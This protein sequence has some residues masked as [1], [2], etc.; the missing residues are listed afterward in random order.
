MEQR[1]LGRSGL[2]VSRLALGTMTWGRDT[3]Q[4]EAR[5]QLLAFV[6]MGGTL[7]DTADVY[8]DGMSEEIVGMLVPEIGR[9]SLVIATKAVS[10]PGSARRFDAS[11]G[12]L[13]RALDA[14]LTR[15]GVDYIDLWQLHA[16]D[17]ATPY[18][19]TLSAVDVAVAS[20]KVRYA[21][22]SN[23]NGWQTAKAA[24]MQTSRPGAAQFVSTQ[25]EYS[26]LERGV[27]RE[28]VGAAADAGLGLLP[29]SPLGR[30]VLTGKYRNGTPADS[31]AASS[32]F[33]SFISPYLGDDSRRVVDALCTAA[34]GLGVSPL[35]V[36]LAW[37]RDRPGVVAPIIGSRTAAQLRGALTVEELT[38]PDEI[39]NALD[40]V[41][42][43]ALGYPDHGWNQI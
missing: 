30:G 31:R 22:I 28:V 35:E 34:E 39:V 41:S 1:P 38:L 8:A 5:D 13:L 33:G 32:H 17:P 29:W 42:A 43:P 9:D 25:V 24:A 10:K 11:R 20:G 12:H 19:E 36:A 40:E 37:V 7:I 6:E 18:E 23:Y 2:L 15:L 21:G 27:E 26:L 3:D 14:S 16:W 4:H